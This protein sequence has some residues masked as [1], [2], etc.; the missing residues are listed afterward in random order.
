VYDT[1]FTAGERVSMPRKPAKPKGPKVSKEPKPTKRPKKAKHQDPFFE[2]ESQKYDSPIPSREFILVA[3]E[4]MGKPQSFEGIAAELKLHSE[5][6]LEALN[7]RLHAMVRDGQLAVNRRGTFGLLDKMRLVA[8]RIQAHKDG[9]GFLVPDDGSKDLYLSPFEMRQVFHGDRA[10]VRE[11][12]PDRKGR[13]EGKIVE[14]LERNTPQVVG[15]Y[16]VEAGVPF[17][18]PS[19]REIAQDILI[20]QGALNP[21]SGDI[22]VVKITHPPTPNKYA[23]GEVV[24]ILGEHMAP[25]L[26]VDVAM[27]AH[28]LPFCFDPEV[29]AEVR[30]WTETVPQEAYAN[31]KDLRDLHFVTI[32]GEDAKDFDDAVYALKTKGG[33]KLYVAIADVAYYVKPGSALDRS[34]YDRGNSVYFPNRVV[35]MLPE[36]LSNGLCSLK[37]DVDRLVMVC[38]MDITNAGVIK[39]YSIYDA[40]ICSKARLTY[41]RVAALLDNEPHDIPEKLIED[42]RTLD[43]LY[44]RLAAQRQKRGAIDFETVETQILFDDNKKISKIMPRIRNKAHKLIEEC[45]L[46]ANQSVA[47]FL[48]EHEM[49][50]LFRVHEK[51]LPEKLSELRQFLAPFGLVLGGGDDPE[52]KHY[53]KL[54]ESIRDRD[55]KHLLQTVTLRSMKQAVYMPD[56]M[57]HFGLAFDMYTHFTSPIRRYP[58][59]LVHRALKAVLAGRVKKADIDPKVLAQQGQHCSMTERRADE[60]TRDVTHWLKCEYMLDHVGE[61][62]EGMITSVTGFGIFVELTDI[63]VE[64]LVH[65]SSLDNDY[66][67]YDAIHHRLTGERTGVIFRIGDKVTVKIAAVHLDDRKIDF[68]LVQKEKRKGAS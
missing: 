19:S 36:I 31:R 42:I 68:A 40:V 62:F 44:E 52:P 3:L 38:E 21:K 45:M 65:V 56:N 26:E 7:R 12:V 16:A 67:Q 66:Y 47:K 1:L 61:I 55:D 51:P 48:I 17:V 59:L 57:G 33:F 18:I 25:G 10:L 22:V 64:G 28:Q 9:F 49:P 54:I 5:Q 43:L 37:S 23:M 39:H 27:R 15:R 29:E 41:T 53:A 11:G 63:Y 50:S 13:H 8:G 32:D 60:A 58:D 30:A 14:V 34:A 4:K 6:D 24:E 35:P 2:R 20:H 46:A